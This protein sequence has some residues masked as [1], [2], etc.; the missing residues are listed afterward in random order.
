MQGMEKDI[1]ILA[2]TITHGGAFV[3][4]VQRLN[5]AFTRARHHLLVVGCSSVLRS[6]SPAFRLLLSSCPHMPAAGG[7][8]IS[9]TCSPARQCIS[10]AA[11]DEVPVLGKS[12]PADAA[13]S[14]DAPTAG[15]VSCEGASAN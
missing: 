15:E 2:T 12:K 3:S 13:A 5:V 14:S 11:T 8:P 4:D 7:L 1:I 6:C 9:S 10:S